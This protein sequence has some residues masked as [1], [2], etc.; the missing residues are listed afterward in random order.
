M[1]IYLILYI[2]LD[3]PFRLCYFYLIYQLYFLNHYSNND[4][5]NCNQSLTKLTPITGR[6]N[7]T[8]LANTF[9]IVKL[10]IDG[11]KYKSVI[12][13]FETYND[14]SQ[15]KTTINAINSSDGWLLGYNNPDTQFSATVDY[16]AYPV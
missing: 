11:S 7:I 16:T 15:L 13:N 5:E 3:L 9:D 10:D 14:S 1:Y 8:F 6:K 4:L 2:R 12:I